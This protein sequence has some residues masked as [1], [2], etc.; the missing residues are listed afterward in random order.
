MG[1]QLR[2]FG[3]GEEPPRPR[4]ERPRRKA[5]FRVRGRLDRAGGVRDGTVTIDRSDGTF[6]VRPLRSRRVYTLP[7]SVV[8]D[9]VVRAILLGDAAEKLSKR[10]RRRR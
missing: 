9:V 5:T 3:A 10:K 8:A 1:E 6:T 7:L 2:I 4:T